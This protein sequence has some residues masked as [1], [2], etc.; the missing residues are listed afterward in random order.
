VEVPAG[1]LEGAADE[2]RRMRVLIQKR[3]W[4]MGIRF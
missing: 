1:E 3:K 2:M 4:E